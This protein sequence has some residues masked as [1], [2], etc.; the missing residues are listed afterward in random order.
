MAVNFICVKCGARG[1]ALL[2]WKTGSTTSLVVQKMKN[3]ETGYFEAEN[4]NTGWQEALQLALPMSEHLGG[5]ESIIEY[6]Q[7]K[8]PNIYSEL[9]NQKRGFSVIV[10]RRAVQAMSSNDVVV[11]GK[12]KHQQL[13]DEICDAQQA[14]RTD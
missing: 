3:N 4:K 5:A 10:G 8:L 12:W 1:Y 6:I 9:E 13:I 14:R 7:T 11:G 2:T